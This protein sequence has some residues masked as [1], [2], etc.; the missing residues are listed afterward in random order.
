MQLKTTIAQAF[1]TAGLVKSSNNVDPAFVHALQKRNAALAEAFLSDER[2]KEF[3]K[4]QKLLHVTKSEPLSPEA[5]R[6]ATE[7]IA[8]DHRHP[9][10]KLVLEAWTEIYFQTSFIIP[11]QELREVFDEQNSKKKQKI[12]KNPRDTKTGRAV[13]SELIQV[14]KEQDEQ[15]ARV[16]KAKG[17][18]QAVA[19]DKKVAARARQQ[20]AGA[21]LLAAHR[22]GDETWR[23]EPVDKLKSAFKCLTGREVKDIPTASGGVKKQDV[24]DAIQ[25]HLLEHCSP[26][27]L[28]DQIE[29]A[30][31]ESP[32]PMF[33]SLDQF[34]ESDVQRS[35]R[36]AGEQAP[37]ELAEEAESGR[38]RRGVKRPRKFAD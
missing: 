22:N 31:P 18:A 10:Y 29:P 14:L 5:A 16:E 3:I 34:A 1:L 6:E 17:D 7:T 8:I 27:L 30:E 36:A 33:L 20:E 13:T 2:D 9:E 35:P 11:A 15:K 37:A 21:A 23:N 28:H 24:I 26:W 25:A 4:K 32:Q 38:P 19:L 12:S